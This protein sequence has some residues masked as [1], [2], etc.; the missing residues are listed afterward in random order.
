[1]NSIDA[2]VRTLLI[3]MLLAGS[4]AW[5]SP[6]AT[7]EDADHRC[8][9]ESCAAVIRGAFAFFDRNLHGLDGNGRSC[10]DCHMVTE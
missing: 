3:Y 7:G 10:N 2:A 9:G 6:P 1:M 8:D 5:A 4:V